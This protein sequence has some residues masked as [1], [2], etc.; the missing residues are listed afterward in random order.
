[1]L[2]ISSCKVYKPVIQKEKSSIK[3]IFVNDTIYCSYYPNNQLD[4]QYLVVKHPNNEIENKINSKLLSVN[5]SLEEKPY[6]ESLKDIKSEL[7][8][9]CLTNSLNEYETT[10]RYESI[11]TKN[12]I[13]GVLRR[14]GMFQNV[15]FYFKPINIDLITGD[16][17]TADKVF[18][19]ENREEL[20]ELCNT[21]IQ[22]TINEL[23]VYAKENKSPKDAEYAESIL[24]IFDVKHDYKFTLSDLNTFVITEGENSLDGIEFIYSLGFP[25]VIK[26]YE[27]DF[28]LFFTFEELEP[29]I[30][31][32]LKKRLEKR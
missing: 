20:V 8:N 19:L 16:E 23:V 11:Y 12:D 31:K 4:M 32:D 2:F 14:V 15:Q 26:A 1:M 17:I 6:S 18:K 7:E 3:S 5:K 27:P 9:A 10:F 25:W 22:N 13:L 28:D 30:Q 21:K 29:F 24:D